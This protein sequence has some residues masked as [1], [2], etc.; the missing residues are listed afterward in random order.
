MGREGGR[1]WIWGWEPSSEG[2]AA[3]HGQPPEQRIHEYSDSRER[4]FG[5]DTGLLL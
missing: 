4:G 3:L 1:D 2:V 5:G